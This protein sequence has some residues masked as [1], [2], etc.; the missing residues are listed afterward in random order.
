MS[1]IS[2]HRSGSCS[3]SL[4]LTKCDDLTQHKSNNDRSSTSGQL[5]VR[6]LFRTR[7]RTQRIR[8]SGRAVL[9]LVVV[10]YSDPE[11]WFT[12]TAIAARRVA[13]EYDYEYRCTEYE[14]DEIRCVARSLLLRPHHGFNR[15]FFGDHGDAVPLLGFARRAHAD[16]VPVLRGNDLQRFSIWSFQEMDSCHRLVD[17]NLGP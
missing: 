10:P 11:H 6:A 8:V 17:R 13:I 14:H 2:L 15:N 9:V 16:Q 3:R 1:P 5:L 12:T 7:T 4:A